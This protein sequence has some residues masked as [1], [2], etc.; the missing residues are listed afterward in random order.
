MR[1][2]ELKKRGKHN[3]QRK[4]CSKALTQVQSVSF[5]WAG[6]FHSNEAAAS[7]MGFLLLRGGVC[8]CVARV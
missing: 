6:E 1:R 5:I 3:V 4:G 2:Q 8:I 7:D